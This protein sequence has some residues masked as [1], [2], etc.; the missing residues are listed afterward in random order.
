LLRVVG[1]IEVLRAAGA[2]AHHVH[3][4]RV[5]LAEDHC[6]DLDSGVFDVG[7]ELRLAVVH[8]GDV[9]AA[10]IDV[11]AILRRQQAVQNP[12]QQLRQR[13]TGR[14]IAPI[15]HVV[16]RRIVGAQDRVAADIGVLAV[17]H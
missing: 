7:A 15:A 3:C 1:A 8:V 10:R 5:G 9:P 4:G 2:A 6:V 16:V 13:I 11:A 14:D 12:E 17:R